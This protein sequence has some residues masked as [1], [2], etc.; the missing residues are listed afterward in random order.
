MQ[1]SGPAK[2]SR[3][4]FPVHRPFRTSHSRS[5]SVPW[6]FRSL[7]NGIRSPKSLSYRSL[8]IHVNI[9]ICVTT[10]LIA[11][12]KVPLFYL[13]GGVVLAWLPTCT[14]ISYIVYIYQLPGEG[15]GT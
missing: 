8:S 2:I 10:S 9:Y 6:T 12:Y 11:S 7:T 4:F 15:V 5:R 1:G 3:F 13:F 14:I